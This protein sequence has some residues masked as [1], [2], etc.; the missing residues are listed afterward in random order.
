MPEPDFPQS[1]L[2]PGI[3][4]ASGLSR[5]KRR[6]EPLWIVTLVIAAPLIIVLILY[7]IRHLF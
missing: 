4:P 6:P 7:L 5:I 1:Q 3:G 2:P